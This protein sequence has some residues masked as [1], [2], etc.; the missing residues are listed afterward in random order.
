MRAVERIPE[1]DRRRCRSEA[2]RRFSPGAMAD[3]Y[4]RIYAEA[5]FEEQVAPPHPD[6]AAFAG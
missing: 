2:E 3:A 6:A 5:L 1:L 4:E